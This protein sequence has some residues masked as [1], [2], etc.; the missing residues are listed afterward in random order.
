MANS[1]SAIFAGRVR[2]VSP[3]WRRKISKAALPNKT[4]TAIAPPM[5]VNSKSVGNGLSQVAECRRVAP[6]ISCRKIA[7]AAATQT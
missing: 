6:I 4:V 3:V 5:C 1:E 2:N 7:T